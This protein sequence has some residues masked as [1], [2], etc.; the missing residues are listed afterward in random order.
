LSDHKS[1]SPVSS[2]NRLKHLV[3]APGKGRHD[4]L[5]ELADKE[6]TDVT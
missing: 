4:T 3:D 6:E 1:E 5:L 2:P